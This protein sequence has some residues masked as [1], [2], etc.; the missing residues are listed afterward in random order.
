MTDGLRVGQKLSLIAPKNNARNTATTVVADAKTSSPQKL[1]TKSYTVKRGE[2]LQLIAER[3]ALS[4]QDLADLTSGLTASSSLLVGQKINVPAQDVKAADAKA[5]PK[6]VVQYDNVTAASTDKT[7]TYKVQRGDTL[8]RIATQ[9][10]ISLSELAEL[11]N[12]KANSG[13]QIGQSLKIPTSVSIPTHYVVQSGDSLNAIA[14]KYNLQL[15]DLAAFNDLSRTAGV[16]IGQRLKLTGDASAEST[17][18]SKE[19][20]K[21]Q[22]KTPSTPDTYMVKSGDT[23][24]GIA[25]RHHLQ[26]DYVAALNDLKRDSTVRIGQKL[27][28]SG[29]VAKTETAPVETKTAAKSNASKNTET[30][31]VKSGESLNSIAN[32]VGLSGRELAELN[33]LKA[34]AGLQ[35][36]QSIVIPKTISEYKVKRGDTLIGLASKYGLETSALAEMNNLPPSTQ[37]RIGTVIKVPNL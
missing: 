33:N 6:N 4:N 20:D 18:K 37:L 22:E 29:E 32:R 21:D 9:S 16:Q 2:Y 36:G 8:S 35:R 24:S 1:A 11:N 15:N 7:E 3:Y 27:K 34:N 30:Y 26:L 12:I 17:A 19:K 14:N 23:L 13:V 5:T 31:T 28:L 25:N 10:K